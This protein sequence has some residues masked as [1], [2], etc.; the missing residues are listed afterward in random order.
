[1]ST[2]DAPY[3][4]PRF[5]VRVSGLTLAA[6]VANQVLSVSYDNNLDLADMFTVVLRN[7]DNQL[8]DS[9]LFDLGKQVEIYLGYGNDLQPMMLGDITAIEP[10]FPKDGPPTVKIVG[11]DKSYKMRHSQPDGRSFQYVP[12]SAIAELIAVEAGLIPI[13]DPSPIFNTDKIIQ[14]V[15]DFAFLKDRARANFFDVYVRWD[16]LYF[17]F[18]RPQTA[19]YVLEWGQNLSSFSP[20]ISSAGLAGLQVVRGYNEELAQA[21]VVF[22]AAADFD[23]SN[24]IEK[25]GSSALDLLTSLGRRVIR[26]QKVESPVDALVVAKSVLQDILDG[27]YAGSGTTIG[28]PGLLA[29]QF[30]TIRNVGQRFSGTYRL[31]KVV[32]T[33]DGEG[34]RTE[35]EVTQRSSG[36]VLQLLR[37]T[38]GTEAPPPDSRER[39]YGV[40][41]GMVTDNV[42]VKAGVPM[43]RVQVQFPWLSDTV[44]SGWARCAM[45]M[46]GANA[47]TFFLPSVGDEVV[48]AFEHGD[49]TKPI[50]L[51]S[52]WNAQQIPPYQN[53]DGFNRI[54]K[55][56]TRR[57][58]T[59][60]LDDT[61]GVEQIVITD[62]AGSSI[63]FDTHSGQI[64]IDAAAAALGVVIEGG[65]SGA[66]RTGDAVGAGGD[67]GIWISNVST[68]LKMKVPTTFGTITGGSQKVY[69]G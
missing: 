43:A 67:M 56:K 5:D 47:G 59:I 63:T 68:A 23:A 40:V 69:I 16:K 24:L 52:V 35:F 65:T 11:Y 31:R 34:Y 10:S 55:I 48:V 29:G 17:Q 7:A 27:L 58:H 32:H 50:V 30:V 54:R 26:D 22:A 36:T 20:R 12:D 57:G 37:K 46:A 6:D 62:R 8:I 25:L 41:T 9:A 21:I 53:A 49:L 15:S 2:A 4:A 1:M 45:P 19:A 64:W 13:V 42:D 51:G 38:L 28:I 61:L 33:I 3:Y 14:T 39:F 60:T 44:T 18:P 66:A